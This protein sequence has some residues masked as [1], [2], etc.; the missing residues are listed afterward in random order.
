[1]P[2][3]TTKP[4]AATL[5][6]SQANVT[7]LTTDLAAKSP[8]VGTPVVRGPFAFAYNT[9]NINN[10]VAFYTPTLNDWLI[11]AWIEVITGFN[12]TTPKA[13]IGQFTGGAGE[14][15]FWQALVSGYP[16][17]SPWSTLSGSADNPSWAG[18]STNNY[19]LIGAGSFNTSQVAPARFR[20]TRPLG[21]VVSQDGTTG[22]TAVGGSAGAAKIYII[23]A[24][25]IA[26]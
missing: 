23:T 22:G 11:E 8:V 4:L 9:A 14:T 16:L 1:M 2:I 19:D 15:G 5:P 17:D 26:F 20:T 24:T 12:G 25:P 13:D 6:I 10:G 3:R 7:N 21:V 18:G